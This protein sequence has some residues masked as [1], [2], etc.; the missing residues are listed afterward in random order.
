MSPVNGEVAQKEK[1][2]KQVWNG[3]EW[4][5][6]GICVFAPSATLHMYLHMAFAYGAV[7]HTNVRYTRCSMWQL[8][9][10]KLAGKGF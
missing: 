9:A 2:Y 3:T 10:I 7:L 6:T 1:V 8:V 4:N 5:R